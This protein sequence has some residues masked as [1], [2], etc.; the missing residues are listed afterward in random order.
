MSWYVYPAGS[1][2]SQWGLTPGYRK[3]TAVCLPPFQWGENPEAFPHQGRSVTF[4]IEGCRDS[5]NPSAGLF[6]EILKSELHPIRATIEA[7]S[8]AATLEGQQEASAAGLTFGKG[9]AD[10]LTLRVTAGAVVSTYLLDR[11]E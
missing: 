3:V 2:A 9:R 6:P 5:R 4:L 11:W 8:R 10:A 7:F 1:Q